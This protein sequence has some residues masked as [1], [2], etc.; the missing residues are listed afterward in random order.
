LTTEE[1]VRSG[2][3]TSRTPMASHRP[4]RAPL[5]REWFE[6]HY[7]NNP[8]SIRQIAVDAGHSPNILRWHARRLGIAFGHDAQP[9]NPFAGWP[10]RRQPPP[11]VVAAC[12]GRR[13]I[14]YVRQVLQMPGH[15]TQRAAAATLGMS[16]HVLMRHRQHVEQAAGLKVF[17]PGSPLVP[18]RECAWFLRQAGEALRRLDLSAREARQ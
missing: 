10:R 12:S 18:T 8:G 1:A 16:E 2:L 3:A 17:E 14:E 6:E 15:R 7:T 4:R 13:G 11:A 5:T 9:F